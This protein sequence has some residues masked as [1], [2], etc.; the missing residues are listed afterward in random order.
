MNSYGLK[1]LLLQVAQNENLDHWYVP[2]SKALSGLTAEIGAWKPGGSVNTIWQTLNH[3]N[4]YNRQVLNKLTGEENGKDKLTNIE[5]FGSPGDPVDE[6]AFAAT[7][8]EAEKLYSLIREELQQIEKNGLSSR[9]LDVAYL[10]EQLPQWVQ[11]DA[12]HIGQIVLIRKLRGDWI[13]N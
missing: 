10:T 4:H 6:K 7:C 8:Q 3:M 9:D 12:Y 2:L 5:T 11:H 13:N 1:S